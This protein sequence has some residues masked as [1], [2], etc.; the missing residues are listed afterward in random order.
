MLTM[1]FRKVCE[2]FGTQSQNK[3]L[4][5]KLR[6]TLVSGA[7]LGFIKQL[8]IENHYIKTLYQIETVSTTSRK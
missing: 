5:V 4:S 3:R 6:V 8:E 2:K 1:D 7:L